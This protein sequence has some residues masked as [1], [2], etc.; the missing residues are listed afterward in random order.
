[1]ENVESF[2]STVVDKEVTPSV[3]YLGCFADI[4]RWT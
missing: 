4:L 3:E 1:M 2:A